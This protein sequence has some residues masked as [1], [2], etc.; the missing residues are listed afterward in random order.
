MDLSRHRGLIHGQVGVDWP[1][2]GIPLLIERV[3]EHWMPLIVQEHS[4]ILAL[5]DIIEA[6]SPA[7]LFAIF[8]LVLLIVVV[9]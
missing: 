3:S 9:N 6:A 8:L 5:D 1:V 2:M 4:L 7:L